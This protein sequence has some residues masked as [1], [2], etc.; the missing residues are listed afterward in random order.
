MTRL[1]RENE[2]LKTLQAHADRKMKA[3][4]VFEACQDESLW[5]LSHT[6]SALKTTTDE[7]VRD[8]MEGAINEILETTNNAVVALSSEFPELEDIVS[9]HEDRGYA[10]TSAALEEWLELDDHIQMA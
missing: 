5:L 4:A 9:S 10:G 3:L 1:T 2:R 7:D 6:L 8:R